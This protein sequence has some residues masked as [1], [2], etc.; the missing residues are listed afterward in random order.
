MASLIESFTRRGLLQPPAFLPANMQY[1]TIMGSVAF[2][3]STDLSDCDL[4]GFAI[5][6]LEELF[7][8]L[9]G[10]IAGFARPL[11]RFENYQEHHV[12]DP[13][14]FG[15]QG[16]EYDFSI[17][18]IQ[19]YFTLCLE[20]N[21]NM[22]ESLFTADDCVVFQTK[23]A[24]LVRERRH[25]FLHKG[26]L[27]RF[28]AYANTQLA[29]MNT[30]QPQGKRKQ[31]QE[32]FGY[33]VKYGYHIV[34]LIYE[35]EQLLQF[36]TVDLRR[37]HEHL[38]AIRRGEVPEA[39]LRAWASNK[40]TQL[41][42]LALRS[43]LP[44]TANEPAVRQLLRDCL[45]EHYGSLECLFTR[46]AGPGRAMRSPVGSK[47]TDQP[48]GPRLDATTAGAPARLAPP[49]ADSPPPANAPTVPP[50]REAG[51]GTA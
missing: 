37:D 25:L 41:D 2:G 33:D 51:R 15:G 42:E 11:S 28:K 38:K 48:P 10:E 43:P 47:S 36:A 5:P 7:P 18:S 4:Y 44:E 40:V 6:P 29:K 39:E 22:I 34:R 46:P 9:A 24:Q 35:C 13:E 32:Q 14:A 19:R 12:Q 16:C 50:G 1:E 3:V 45:E 23:V 26:V 21:P 30:K 31:L 17:F 8:H 27:Q 49:Q 20:C